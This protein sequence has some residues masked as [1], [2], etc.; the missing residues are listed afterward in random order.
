MTPVVSLFPLDPDEHADALQAV[1]RATPHYWQLYHLPSSP[2]G[3]ARRDLEAAAST[4]GRSM[5][6]I[7]RRVADDNPQT[8]VEMVGVVDFRLHWPSPAVVYVGMVMVAE[9]VQRQGIATQAWRVLVPWLA[10]EA[11]MT[12]ARVGVEQFNPGALRFFQHIGFTMT[13]E[14]QRVQSGKRWVR[15]LYLESPL[16]ARE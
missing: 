16:A 15:L 11:G 13:G 8:G 6:G 12:T 10:Q 7:V 2:A 5:L 1:Y 9:P 14:A 4:P 3:Q